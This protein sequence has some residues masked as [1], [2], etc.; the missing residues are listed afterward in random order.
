MSAWAPGHIVFSLH[1]PTPPPSH[2][3]G[4]LPPGGWAG[5]WTG[6]EASFT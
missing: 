5:E 6:A 2:P 1:R 3:T 4:T